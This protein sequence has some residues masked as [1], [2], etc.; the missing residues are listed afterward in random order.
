[1]ILIIAYGHVMR[2]RDAWD[3]QIIYYVPIETFSK[4]KIYVFVLP[5]LRWWDRDRLKSHNS[6]H[7]CRILSAMMRL[8]SLASFLAV[9][10]I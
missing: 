9:A 7:A 6:T 4:V 8:A 10:L 5:G 2:L 3:Y 1:M